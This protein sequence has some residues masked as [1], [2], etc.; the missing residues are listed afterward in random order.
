[1]FNPKN[2]NVSAAATFTFN[3]VASFHCK[4]GIDD[5]INLRRNTFKLISNL[6]PFY[7]NH[8][9][10]IL[11]KDIF[12]IFFNNIRNTHFLLSSNYHN[13]LY[14]TVLT[15][16]DYILIIRQ[17]SKYENYFFLG[18]IYANCKEHF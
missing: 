15:K 11:M 16:F 7:F 13:L 2:T 6:A 10:F 17:I 5:V 18:I 12:K 4:P 8:F 14:K 3:N 9:L 1:M